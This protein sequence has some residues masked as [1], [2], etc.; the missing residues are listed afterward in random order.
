MVSIDS[1]YLANVADCHVFSMPVL[2]S[3]HGNGLEFMAYRNLKIKQ[4]LYKQWT[5]V[6][7]TVTVRL[8]V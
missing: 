8:S 7:N 5:H 1:F 3:C 6:P 2:I 4:T